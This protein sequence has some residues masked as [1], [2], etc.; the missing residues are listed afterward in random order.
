MYYY[1]ELMK[2]LSKYT[3]R[4]AVLASVA[5]MAACEQDPKFTVYDYP[6]PVVENV[7]P[8]DGF[9]TTQ[10][11]ITG[12]NFGDRAGSCKGFLWRYPVKESC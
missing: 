11:V 10:V 4:L 7:Y 3:F 2:L 6:V 12:T 5:L 1:T 9:V 8:T